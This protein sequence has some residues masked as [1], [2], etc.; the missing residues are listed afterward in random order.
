M[1][2]NTTRTFLALLF[3]FVSVLGPP[4]WSI[5]A[6]RSLI[7]SG[8]PNYPPS[9]FA[10]G[11]RIEGAAAELLG[12]I[13]ADLGLKV[14]SVYAGPWKRVQVLA[15]EGRIDVITTIYK[16]PERE[17]YLVYTRTPYM[18]DPN[19]IWVWKGREFA[20]DA[21]EDLKG[22]TGGAIVGDSYGKDFDAYIA[23][24]LNIERVASF[25]QN[26][27][28]LESGRIDYVPY[29]LYSGIMEAKASGY[30]SKIERLPK[31]LPSEGLYIA[32]SAKSPYVKYADAVSDRIEALVR[33][34]T[35]RR[36]VD[37]YFVE[38]GLAR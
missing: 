18:D 24:N 16:T 8:N 22:K 14:E 12:I 1:C 3:L 28:K 21:W 10:R 34:G 2:R 30:I 27:K 15:E 38:E 36:L 13:F 32:F 20:F 6:E 25:E 29:G 19:V 33:D 11:E 23:E 17:R 5:A 31:P 7:A 4:V 26:M 9:S 35:V 37:K